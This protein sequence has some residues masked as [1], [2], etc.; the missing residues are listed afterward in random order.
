MDQPKTPETPGAALSPLLRAPPIYPGE[1]KPLTGSAPLPAGTGATAGQGEPM[2][3]RDSGGDRDNAVCSLSFSQPQGMAPKAPGE[4]IAIENNCSG[5]SAGTAN[6]GST[7][8]DPPLIVEASRNGGSGGDSA[9]DNDV[10]SGTQSNDPAFTNST[11]SANDCIDRH[12]DSRA[13]QRASAIE[14]NGASSASSAPQ[15]AA[16]STG[17]VKSSVNGGTGAASPSLYMSPSP[18]RRSALEARSLD[19]RDAFARPRAGGKGSLFSGDRGSGRA[20]KDTGDISTST[21]DEEYTWFSSSK[22]GGKIVY[23]RVKINDFAQVRH[24]GTLFQI[25]DC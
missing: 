22:R 21:S 12:R 3:G 10:L 19:F 24:E 14:N 16:T 7:K 6:T 11:A 20:E 2:E 13:M 4:A 25:E 15:A 5:D 18:S 23:D 1:S 9:A 8:D 17:A